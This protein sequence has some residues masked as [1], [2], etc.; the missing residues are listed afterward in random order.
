MDGGQC[1]GA[2]FL[3]RWI[4]DRRSRRKIVDE[5]ELY[6]KDEE[7]VDHIGVIAVLRVL[8]YNPGS[9]FIVN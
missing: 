5:Q 6:V 1:Y 3:F 7:V 2:I 8:V 9:R 4:D